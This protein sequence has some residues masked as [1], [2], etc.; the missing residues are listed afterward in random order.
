VVAQLPGGDVWGFFD[1]L[2]IPIQNPWLSGEQAAYYNG[3]VKDTYISNLVVFVPDGTVVHYEL[4]MP[5]S[6]HD[7]RLAV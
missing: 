5:G 3:W 1:G 7:A 4:N 6:W 2:K